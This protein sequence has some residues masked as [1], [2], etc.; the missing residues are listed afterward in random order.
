M[1]M[2][3]TLYQVDLVLNDQRE[4]E[5]GNALVVKTSLIEMECP[6]FLKVVDLW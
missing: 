2:W 3:N 6:K 4:Y 1:L 5:N